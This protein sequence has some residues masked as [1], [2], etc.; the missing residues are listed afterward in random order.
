MPIYEYACTSCRHEFELL[1]PMGRVNEPADCP[2]CDGRALRQLSVFA[3]FSTGSDGQ[4]SAVSGG[5]GGCCGGGCG[6][7]ACGTGM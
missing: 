7:G 5:G 1:R 4:M 3:S 6:G 2:E